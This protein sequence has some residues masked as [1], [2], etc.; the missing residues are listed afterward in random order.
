VPGFTPDGYLTRLRA[1]H[2]QI[3]RD[4]VFVSTAQRLL[5]EARSPD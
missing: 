5:V 3:E 1:L 2:E 4:G